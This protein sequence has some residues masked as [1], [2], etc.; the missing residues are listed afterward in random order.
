MSTT[1][2]FVVR[3]VTSEQ[4]SR[5]L[6]CPDCKL[7]F[8]LFQPDEDEPTLL[9]GTCDSCAKWVYLVELEPDWK[10]SIMIELPA[11]KALQQ[12]LVKAKASERGQSGTGPRS[13]P[14]ASSAS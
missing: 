14:P 8:N 4:D 12:E 10:T 7:Q 1:V 13:Q 3:T 2:G 11:R 6:C 5:S 9:L